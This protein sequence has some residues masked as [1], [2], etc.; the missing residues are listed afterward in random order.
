M[1]SIYIFL[2]L[3]TPLVIYSQDVIM[4]NVTVLQCSGI[5]YDSGGISGNYS[6]AENFAITICPDMPGQFL[7]L[8]FTLFNTELDVDRMLIYDGPDTSSPLIGTFSGGIIGGT[9]PD[10]VSATLGNTSGCL[11][12]QF[13]SNNS[14]TEAG[15]AATISCFKPCQTITSQLDSATP[16]P[17]SDDYI[18][19]CREEEITLTGS[20]IFSDD[21]TGATYEWDL[22]D[23]RTI[24][25]QTATFSYP[26]PGVYLVNLIV[27]DTNTDKNPEGCTNKNRFNQVIQVANDPDFSGT[28][29]DKVSL[30][31]GEG[32]TITIEGVVNTV[33][34]NKDCTN[35]V[36]GS[37]FLPDG[38]G[39]SYETSVTVQCYE[40]SQTLTNINQLTSICLT[41]EH[42]F[43]DDLT[44]EII[45]PNNQTVI[46]HN[47]G[48]G[49]ANLG[50]PWATGFI[51]G[52]SENITS[53]VGSQYCFVPDTSL[54]TLVGGILTGGV[55]ISGN[56]PATYNDNYV[57][58]GNYSSISPLVGL[59]GSPL[60][61][62]WTI[63]VT[64]NQNQDNGYIFEWSIDFDPSILPVSLTF[65][66]VIT[67]EA[68]D[69]DPAIINT[70]GNT[71]TV[72]L[73]SLG[74]YCYTYRVTNDF[75]CE[76][77][78][79][80]CIESIP[81]IIIDT[82]KKLFICET[83]SF[84]LS[85]NTSVIVAPS[86]NPTDLI[87]T[88]YE[89]FA[90]AESGEDSITNPTNYLGVN[91]QTIYVR[92]EYLSSGCFK[93]ESFILI[94]YEIP[95]IS[96]N[97][98]YILCIDTNG[99]EEIP[100]NPL[101]DT[102]LDTINYSFEW[103]VGGTVLPFETGS[104]II[105]N[106]V[107]NYSVEVTNRL[108]NCSSSATINIVISSPPIISS[109]VSY[110]FIENNVIQVTAMG[111]GVYEYNLDDGSWQE[112]G[113][114]E[115][116]SSG[117]HIVTARDL[118]GC[119]TN[120]AIIIVIGFPKFFTPNGDGYHDTWNILG[121]ANQPDAKIFIFDRYGKLIKQLSSSSTG[122]DGTF[123]GKPLMT[124]DYWFTVEFIEPKDGSLKLF[125]S[126]FT[127]KR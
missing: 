80:V 47:R 22:G 68:W 64:D 34:F 115:N 106:Q 3:I 25:G 89:T 46:L 6:N 127:L 110:A 37:I 113:V 75:G 21:G 76:Y 105:A 86:L 72:Q 24:E 122:W 84:D 62:D 30:C 13:I 16:M 52:N 98:E 77:T 101:I 32:E 57:P 54:P 10:L 50:I 44:I 41:M 29:A 33:D 5:F 26:N 12:I 85:I 96:L 94:V 95:I 59:L 36:S 103:F 15:W 114:F 82:P 18:R 104:S 38:N 60:N 97:D 55:F 124:N 121:I 58:E 111:N 93:T 119:G 51:D 81:E 109:S 112:S 116:V 31:F 27:Y 40:P 90:S 92:I 35:P 126:H 42:S 73:P 19:V 71:I 45:S 99:T 65:N 78:K 7:E 11:T 66:T 63:R 20:A 123:N 2:F 120:S 91:E 107:G 14:V 61:G 8:N 108:T 83:Y 43:L 69:S 1:K 125:K 88:Y 17:N 67:S 48:G 87:I 118:N 56:G 23:G 79:V 4:D 39:V 117:E 70:T 28:K 100:I 53:G 74:T 49:S 102:G 9:S